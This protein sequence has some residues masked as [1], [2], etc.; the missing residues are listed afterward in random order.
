MG[1]ESLSVD[2]EAI[3]YWS[4]LMHIINYNTIQNNTIQ[5]NSTQHS[6]TAQT[7]YLGPDAI[8]IGVLPMLSGLWLWHMSNVEIKL[9]NV[10]RT[11]D[12]KSAPAPLLYL[13]HAC[14]A[15]VHRSF[16]NWNP[17]ASN[18]LPWTFTRSLWEVSWQDRFRSSPYKVS[19]QDI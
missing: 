4:E 19:A 7:G 12:S 5:L 3:F 15:G 11:K 17:F 16:A 9:T 13:F 2:Q 14:I 10:P 6:H 18:V 1:K 8:N